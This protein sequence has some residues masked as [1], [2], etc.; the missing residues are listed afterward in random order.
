MP[1]AAFILGLL[2]L[3]VAL[4]ALGWNIGAWLM[5]TG[6]ARCILLIGVS[7]GQSIVFSPVGK[8]GRVNPAD[9]DRMADQG[10]R[11]VGPKLLGV[12]VHNVGRAP[13]VVSRY[14]AV[15]EP[16]SLS[17]SPV[18]DSLGPTLPHSIAPGD[19]AQWWISMNEIGATATT[20]AGVLIDE[21][22]GVHM[23]VSTALRKDVRT[24]T[25]LFFGQ[26]PP[27]QGSSSAD[28][29]TDPGPSAAS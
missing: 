9:I 15:I 27:S 17:L 28:E 7:N 16:K 4:L 13:L 20:A 25:S 19:S 21:V 1:L 5:S 11:F 10:F 24:K 23:M 26:P 22:T 8:N 3:T 29:T 12:E 2:S 6:R 14:T 18:A